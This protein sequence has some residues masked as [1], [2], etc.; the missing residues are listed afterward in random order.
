MCCWWECRLLQPLWKPV[1]SFLKKLSMEL[2]FDTVFPLLG[3]YLKKFKTLTQKNIYTPI[4]TAV[5]SKIAKIWKQ[6]KCPSL[7]EWIKKA[8]V[9]LHNGIGFGHKKDGNFT[10]A[11]AWM[12]LETIMLSEISQRKTNT[13]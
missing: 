13:I 3:I 5:S 8:V 12:D 9:Y 1:R 10:F 11:T 4:F 6:L 2:L 7:D